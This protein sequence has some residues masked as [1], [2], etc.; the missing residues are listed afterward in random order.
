[1]RMINGLG[2]RSWA[3][4]TGAKSTLIC[5]NSKRRRNN[6]NQ[7]RSL[8]RSR[9]IRAWGVTEAVRWEVWG[10]T[11]AQR[12]YRSTSQSAQRTPRA[13]SMSH[14]AA[15]TRSLMETDYA[16]RRVQTS[17]DRPAEAQASMTF[18]VQRHHMRIPSKRLATNLKS[19]EAQPEPGS[20]NNSNSSQ[21]RIR[22]RLIVNKG[23]CRG[24]SSRRMAPTIT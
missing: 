3:L 16:Y 10:T 9:T 6:R 17:V 4:T 23:S 18:S 2:L 8:R 21:I 22:P 15:K 1:M 7:R 13:T 19:K 14:S 20:Q 11:R 12:T 5:W 24:Y